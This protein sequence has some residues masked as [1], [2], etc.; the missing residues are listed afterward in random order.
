MPQPDVSAA[1]PSLEEVAS[2]ALNEAQRQ[3]ASQAESDVSVSQ[4]L[5]V[6]VRLGEVD[7][8]EYQRGHGL[9]RQAQ[10]LG[11]HR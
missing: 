1:T 11:Q 8:V 3:G 10:G 2:L 4:G 7:T 5:S 9:F 6:N